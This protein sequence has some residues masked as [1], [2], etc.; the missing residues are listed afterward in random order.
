MRIRY[1]QICF[2]QVRFRQQFTCVRRFKYRL[3]NRT[4]GSDWSRVR[5]PRDLTIDVPG[6]LLYFAA[7]DGI[8]SVHMDGSL[9]TKVSIEIVSFSMPY[10]AA[11][12][13]MF[14]TSS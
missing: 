1:K 13:N 11:L 6:G 12:S 7:D 10:T 4:T 9:L 2:K 5:K 8:Y 14:D 3:E